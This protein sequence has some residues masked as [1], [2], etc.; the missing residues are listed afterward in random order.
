[1]N[2]SK[3]V[4]TACSHGPISTMSSIWWASVTVC[5][6]VRWSRSLQ[7]KL[8]HGT[9]ELIYPWGKTVKVHWPCQLGAK[10]KKI[11]RCGNRSWSSCVRL[12]TR[13]QKTNHFFFFYSLFRAPV[14]LKMKFFEIDFKGKLILFMAIYH[15]FFFLLITSSFLKKFIYFRFCAKFPFVSYSLAN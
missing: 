3:V 8:W 7:T 6:R 11:C 10:R 1:M 12:R 4:A 15:D 9:E 13:Q 2:E 14:F 5:G